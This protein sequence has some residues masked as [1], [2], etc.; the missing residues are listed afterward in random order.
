[1]T[2]GGQ[3]SWLRKRRSVTLYR[4]R[5]E[6]AAWS[7]WEAEFAIR[8]FTKS[9]KHMFNGE[10]VHH[11]LPIAP[12]VNPMVTLSNKYAVGFFFNSYS[13]CSHAAAP[14]SHLLKPALLA[15]A[16]ALLAKRRPVAKCDDSLAVPHAILLPSYMARGHEELVNT[17][18]CL[19]RV[20]CAGGALGLAEK[21]GEPPGCSR[22]AMFPTRAKTW[23]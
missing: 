20:A 3:L 11:S 9:K 5:L 4:E 15:L 21:M 18:A 8:Q 10:L 16:V 19:V 1:M 14:S 7:G 17:L 6:D 13:T 12:I 2:A 22:G 23:M